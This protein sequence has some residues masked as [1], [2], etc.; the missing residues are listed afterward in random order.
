LSHGEKCMFWG[1]VTYRI[2]HA[3]LLAVFVATSAGSTTVAAADADQSFVR[4][5]Q[6]DHRYFELSDGSPYIPIGLNMIAPAHTLS[7]D[8]GLADI[9]RWIRNLSDNGGNFARIWL[10]N[11]FWDIE[12]EKSGS[13]DNDK[14][15]RIDALLDIGRKYGVRLK[16]TMEHFRSF[17]NGKWSGKPLHHIS[18]GG[19]A[20]SVT[21]FFTNP[22]CRGQF[23]RKIGWYAGRY[24]SNPTVFAWELWNEMD[25][26]SGKGWDKWTQEM[27]VELHRRFPENLA[28][29]SLG[30]FDNESKRSRY[31]MVCVMPENDIAQVHRYLDLG[32]RLEVCHGPVDVLT[33]DAIKELRIFKPGK[34]ILLAESGAVEPSH[35]GPFKLYA[36]DKAGI[37]LHDVLFA[38]FFTGAAGSGQIWHWD[39]YVDRNNLW[40]QFGR[41]AEAVKGIDPAGEEFEPV[42]LSDSQLRI[43]ALKGRNVS[44]AFCRDRMNTW[45]SELAEQK[46]PRTMRKARIELA[47][48]IATGAKNPVV[49]VYNPW[50]NRRSKSTIE[51]GSVLLPDFSRSI[52]VTV[53]SENGR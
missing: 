19:L 52:V 32:A 35:S 17:D 25:C 3:C 2:R 39:H 18:N 20:E 8:S 36:K 49:E 6:R 23:K 51:H 1:F 47:G 41:F 34:P 43:Y 33:S 45:Q 15:R 50:T 24:G 13:Y 5:S 44:I 27:L 29:Q 7:T 12:H 10:S 30:S 14:A 53:R 28:T 37:I 9:E 11:N 38:P 40:W 46:P 26:V 42:E 31:R 4:V 21:D 48:A 22:T 16:L